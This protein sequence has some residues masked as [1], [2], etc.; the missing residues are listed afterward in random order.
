M[1]PDHT[2]GREDQV[3]L[4]ERICAA[5]VVHDG[6]RAA[7]ALADLGQRCGAVPGLADLG[8]LLAVPAVRELLAGVFGASPYLTNLIERNPES[9]QRALLASPEQRFAEL[10]AGATGAA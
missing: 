9:L 5:P 7:S 3:P 6:A 2:G 4:H 10:V 8:R 1:S